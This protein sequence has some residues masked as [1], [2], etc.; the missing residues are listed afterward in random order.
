MDAL[1]SLSDSL[2][3]LGQAASKKLFHVPSPLGGRTALSFDG[4]RLLV[5][6]F[7]AEE[8]ERLELLGPGGKPL[9]AAV[10]GFDSGRGLAVLELEAALPETAFKAAPGLPPLGSL[11]LAAAYPSPQGP[12]LR[13]DLVR[14]SG[15]EGEESY[16]Q[17]DGPPFPGFSGAALVDPEGALAG[18]LLADRPGNRGWALP[19]ARAE[20]LAKAIAERGFEGRAWLGLSTLPVEAPEGFA[21]LFGDGRKGALLLIG[22]EPEGPAAKAGLLPGDFLVS[23]GGRAVAEPEELRAALG[24]VRPGEALAVVAIR[25]GK[26]LELEALT[27]TAEGRERR[28]RRGPRDRSGCCG[29]MPWGRGQGR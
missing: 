10:K 27:G 21:A 5:P 23:L 17:T 22:L 25:G 1:R 29:G 9:A 24:S 16:L 11:L 7:D 18:F 14:F 12:E 20:A 13:L 26:R 19:A 2:A 15:G 28:G 4:K 8:G 6:A 3:A